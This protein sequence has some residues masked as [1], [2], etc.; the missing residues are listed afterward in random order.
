MWEIFKYETVKVKGKLN[1]IDLA[2]YIVKLK[3]FNMVKKEV[4]KFGQQNKNFDSEDRRLEHSVEVLQGP[5]D[6]WTYC[7]IFLKWQ[8]ENRPSWFSG[9]KLEKK[10]IERFRSGSVKARLVHQ[11]Q[12]T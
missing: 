3:K 7:F 5:N 2:M 1:D 11:A 8:W 9:T 10:N 12:V 6:V 4:E